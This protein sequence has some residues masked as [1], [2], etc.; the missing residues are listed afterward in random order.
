[1]SSL[2]FL[3]ILLIPTAYGLE[4]SVTVIPPYQDAVANKDIPD[5][6]IVNGNY[7][8]THY[9]DNKYQKITE[10]KGERKKSFLEHRWTINVISGNKTEI[11]F[12]LE[13]YHTANKE[14]EHFVFAYSLDDVTYND[15]VKVTRNSDDNTYQN[16]VMPKAISGSVY[17]RVRD[18]NRG[19][20][21]I[22]KDTIYIDHMFI[23]SQFVDKGKSGKTD[24]S[25]TD[26]SIIDTSQDISS[27]KAA[28]SEDMIQSFFDYVYRLLS[29]G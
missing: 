18:M 3:Y 8:Y 15:M 23:R 11:T 22:S 4:Y 14:K 10:I 21:E 26:S 17:I 19:E 20:G 25:I 1:M 12:Y 6:G 7:T 29:G 9:S 5:E 2:F 16:F 28:S 24:S 27:N 13:A